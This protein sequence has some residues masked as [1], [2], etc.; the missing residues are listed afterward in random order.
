ME[1]LGGQRWP[2]FEQKLLR[3]ASDKASA[4]IPT[5]FRLMEGGSSY[6]SNE[7]RIPD[8]FATYLKRVIKGRWPE[9]EQVLLQRY[10]DYPD[11]W[12]S[13]QGIPVRL[14]QPGRDSSTKGKHP[15]SG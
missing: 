12:E 9:L 3:E 7:D 5:D 4:V 10:E 2:E 13:N 14:S 1:V 6:S 15:V 8:P 11:I